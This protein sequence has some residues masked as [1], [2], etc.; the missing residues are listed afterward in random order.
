MQ[1]PKISVVILNYNGM[2]FVANCLK[3]LLLTNYPDFEVLFLDNA[4]SDG[5]REYL[6]DAIER[7]G[8]SNFKFIPLDRNYGF[9]KAN[10]IGVALTDPKSEFIIFLNN[11]TEVEP[12]WLQEIIKFM[13]EH[14][15]VGIAQCKQRSLKGRKYIDSAGGV[16]DYIGR[17]LIIGS[18]ELDDERFSRPYEIFYAQ[19]SSLIIR[20]ELLKRI[21]LF[22][23]D[24]FINYEETDLCWRA[25]LS[26]L[27]VAFIPTAIIYHYGGATIGQ[28]QNP[29]HVYHTRKNH[30]VTLLKNYSLSNAIKYVTYLYIK[31]VMFTMKLLSEKKIQCASAY[32]KA[33]IWPIINLKKIATARNIVQKFV[34]RV[35]DEEIMEKM[36]DF[37]VYE[38]LK[39]AMILRNILRA[40]RYESA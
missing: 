1:H 4:S 10:N 35:S 13:Q 25:R 9:A 18:G 27:K 15:D 37:R 8:L 12:D 26:G 3:S 20:R 31:Y 36:L 34:R 5:S 29:F 21:G 22:D 7:L 33:M 32:V 39:P 2:K 24:Y 38:A 16:I 14:R 28:L 11:D 30:I 19:G 23:E 6:R 40:K 17:S